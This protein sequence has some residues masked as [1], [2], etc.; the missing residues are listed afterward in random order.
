MG[1]ASN[2]THVTRLLPSRSSQDRKLLYLNKM[3]GASGPRPNYSSR[4]IVLKTALFAASTFEHRS[5]TSLL[6]ALQLIGLF[7]YP[8]CFTTLLDKGIRITEGLLY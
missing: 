5:V 2:C 4:L 3:A 1:G 7:T 8:A 6:H